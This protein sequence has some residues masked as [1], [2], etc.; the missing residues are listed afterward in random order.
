MIA[1]RTSRAEIMTKLQRKVANKI[2]I[3]IASAGCAAG[4]CLSLLRR[5]DGYFKKITITRRNET[6]N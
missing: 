1:S 4:I 3:F 5:S 2:P 6:K